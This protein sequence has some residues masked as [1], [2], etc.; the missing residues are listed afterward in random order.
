MA[1]QHVTFE[2]R[3]GRPLAGVLDLPDDGKVRAAA[4]LAHCFTCGKDLKGLVRMSR[5]LVEHGFAVLRFD[6]T[7]MGESG[8]TPLEGGLG[9]DAD[10]VEDAA[11]WLAEHH[12]APSLLVGHSLGGLAAILAAER[13][14][15][16]VALAT[17]GTPSEPAHVLNLVSVD[18]STVGADEAVETTI[19]GRSF[20]L[21]G[22]FFAELEARTPLACL[23][24]LKL[25]LLVG[26]S[27]GGLAAILAAERIPSLVALAT[28]GTPSEPA[29]VLNLV[30][31]DPSTVGADE[32]VE[33]T[34]AGRSFTLPG[35]FFAELEART[36]LA[37]L[38]E[39]KLPLL[40]LHAVTDAV[41]S[42]KHA[43]AL[44]Q[45][46]RDP[47][48]AYVSLGQA[49]H[50]LAKESD[51]RFAGHVLGAWAAS[52]LEQAGGTMDVTANV[53]GQPRLEERLSRAVTGEGYATDAYAGGHPMR[54]DEPLTAGGT[55]TGPTPVEA[56]RSALAACTTITLR[57]YANRKEWP[58]ERIVCDVT[59]KSERRDGE[60][61]THFERRIELVG[62]LDA[63]QR[64][65]ILEIA[66]R[67][68]V[69]RSLEGTVTIETVEG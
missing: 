62:D 26:H 55:D 51:A 44:F 23:R 4:L 21:P 2:N 35:R 27:L 41:V 52:L 16:L 37:C 13:M 3:R 10:D 14:P 46:A 20:T 28:I 5:T 30:S 31:V 63:E 56:L 19:A 50:L 12:A 69:H 32:A 66:D 34:I 17:I 47:R 22:R 25:P 53:S 29:H 11:A 60:V 48:K 6:F 54:F 7:G 40:V 15:S 57:M 33:T 36:P 49:D 18:P 1:T 68:P 61:F 45:A 58:L 8:G 24:E 65:R 59:S 43:E 42:V 64:K 67:C 39:L 9:G 38:R